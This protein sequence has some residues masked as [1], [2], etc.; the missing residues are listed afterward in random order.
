MN[1][2]SP[3][4]L[5]RIDCH[6]TM[7]WQEVGS[8]SISDDERLTFPDIGKTPGLYRITIRRAT[9]RE[10]YIGEAINLRRRFHNYRSPGPTQETSR[11]INGLLMKV[12]AEGAEVGVAVALEAMIDSGHGPEPADLTSKVTRCLAENAAILAA[13]RTADR[14]HNLAQKV[15]DSAEP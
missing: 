3:P 13:A 9:L 4:P 7:A 10:V 8:V 1:D 6:L 15:P 11:R 12:L 5:D 2:L 14:I